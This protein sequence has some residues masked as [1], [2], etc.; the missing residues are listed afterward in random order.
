MRSQE[1]LDYIPL[2]ALFG[3]TVILLSL[4]VEAGFQVGSWRQGDAEHERETP[5]GAIV[6][7]IFGLPAFLIAFTYGLAAAHFELRRALVLQEANAIGTTYLR[8]A[9]VPEPHR[10]EVRTL[11]R[12]Y[13]DIR[14]EGVEKGMGEPALARSEELQG[15]LW[16]QAVSVAE[17]KPTPITALL[18]QSLNEVIDL[19]ATRVSLGMRNRIPITIW[20]ALYFTVMFAMVGVGYYAGLTSKTRT[21]E[22]LILV[23]TFSGVLLML[24]DLDRPQEGLLK[25]S[26]QAMVDLRQSMKHPGH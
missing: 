13:V 3:A 7:A 5:V 11:L 19:H 6:A 10:E 20:V 21:W 26:Q 16:E 2:W 23:V 8:A 25:V 1:P 9:L 18:I 22:T 12:E 14:L 4:A 17:E 15:S 24:A